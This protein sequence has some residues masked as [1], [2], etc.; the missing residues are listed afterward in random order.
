MAELA[1]FAVAAVWL[2]FG[3]GFKILN[4]MP[5]HQRIVGRVLGE[6]HAR[7][8]TVL[9][10]LGECAIGVWMASGRELVACAAVQTVAIVIMNALE[11]RLVRDLLLSP[12]LMVAANALLLSLAWFAALHAP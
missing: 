5:R 4:L 8:L 1:R 11:L 3:A 2:V 9:I 12:R 6:R 7:P 10:G